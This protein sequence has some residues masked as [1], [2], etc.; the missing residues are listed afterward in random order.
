MKL[1]STRWVVRLGV[2]LALAAALAAGRSPAAAVAPAAPMA[3]LL[4]ATE[5]PPTGAVTP[6]AAPAATQPISITVTISGT[7]RNGTAGGTVP[8]DLPVLLHG[9]GAAGDMSAIASLSTTLPASGIYRFENVPGE[10]GGQWLASAEYKDILYTSQPIKLVEGQT[11]IDLPVTIYET[12]TTPAPLEVQQLHLFLEFAPNSV[13]VGEL[14]IL[15]NPGDRTIVNA[16]GAVDFVLPTGATNLNVQGEQ[17]GVNYVRT[18]QGFSEVS[19]VL[20]GVAQVL[21]SFDLPYTDKLN[22]EQKFLYPVNSAGVLLAEN[23]VKLLSSQLADQGTQSVQGSAYHIYG[24]QNLTPGTVLAF[25]LS[26]TPGTAAA[27]ASTPQAAPPAFDPRSLAV[28]VGVLGVVVLGVGAWFYRRQARAAPVAAAAGAAS[29]REDL[30]EE[31]VELD[32]AFEAG[33]MEKER[34]ERERAQ[35]KAE[36]AKLM[37][38]EREL[39]RDK[40]P[41][42]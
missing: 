5:P 13:T 9:V 23:G 31:I 2:L 1:T 37:A 3:A 38:R 30:L 15:N 35:L 7:V 36:L 21:Y 40:K 20:P 42:D 25:Q 11:Q 14:Y 4:Q 16:Q 17:E 8:A 39:G 19:P 26:G 33:K 28:G 10:V 41:R 22:F 34:Y 12:M 6:E 18:A 27:G 32:D 24:A 29:E